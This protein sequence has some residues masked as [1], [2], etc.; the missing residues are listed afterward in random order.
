MAIDR[1]LLGKAM[2]KAANLELSGP[3]AAGGTAGLLSLLPL[4]GTVTGAGAGLYH[5]PPGRVLPGLVRGTATGATTGAG[6]ALGGAV[7]GVGSGL[8][9]HLL[10]AN[11][12]LAAKI[13]VG[14]A[15][16]G[17]GAGGYGG[18]RLG[19]Y[20]NWDDMGTETQSK[21]KAKPVAEP[22]TKAASVLRLI[23]VT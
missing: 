20:L 21:K 9:A 1:D 3:M 22:A 6:A 10:G 5:A 19:K 15:A 2:T 17:A 13:G 11:P 14:G 12:E 18:H 8:L 16:V 7:G 4:L 23:L